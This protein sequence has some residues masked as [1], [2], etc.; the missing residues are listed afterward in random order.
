MCMLRLHGFAIFMDAM[1]HIISGASTIGVEV[2]REAEYVAI[3][4]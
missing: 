1:N 4:L 2:G 3:A